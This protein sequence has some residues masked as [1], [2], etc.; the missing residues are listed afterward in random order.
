M[1]QGWGDV[2]VLVLIQY[3]IPTIYKLLCRSLIILLCDQKFR[4]MQGV[5]IPR[6]LF[7]KGLLTKYFCNNISLQKA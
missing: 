1:I 2:P 7:L 4:C 6:V 5:V 3:Q